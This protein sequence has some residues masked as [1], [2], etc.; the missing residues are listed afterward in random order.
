MGNPND[1]VKIKWLEVLNKYGKR[2]TKSIKIII[3]NTEE[4]TE[5][6]PLI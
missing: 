1:R 2:P 4:T 5:E 6:I 3:I